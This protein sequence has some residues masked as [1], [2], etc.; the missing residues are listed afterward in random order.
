MHYA[1]IILALQKMYCNMNVNS[2]IGFIPVHTIE[3]S[4]KGVIFLYLHP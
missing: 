1:V 3:I 4:R 2:K